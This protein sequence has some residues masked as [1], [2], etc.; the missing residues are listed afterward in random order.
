MTF[1]QILV[2]IVVVCISAVE[3]VVTLARASVRKAMVGVPD[4]A[5][6]AEMIV[7]ALIEADQT[8]AM[9]RV[10]FNDRG[11]EMTFTPKEI[12]ERDDEECSTE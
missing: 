11:T 1:I 4:T 5:K 2:L 8:G 7:G 12:F 10:T 9:V 3:C 6:I